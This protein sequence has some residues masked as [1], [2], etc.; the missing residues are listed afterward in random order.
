MMERHANGKGSQKVMI[1]M[2]FCLRLSMSLGTSVIPLMIDAVENTFPM[3]VNAAPIG[4]AVFGM[5]KIL[6]PFLINYVYS[7]CANRKRIIFSV[8]LL[9]LM[10]YVLGLMS[11]SE[12]IVPLLRLSLFLG[13]GFTIGIS[14]G[15]LECVDLPFLKEQSS[16]NIPPRGIHMVMLSIAGPCGSLVSFIVCSVTIVTDCYKWE[17]AYYVFSVISGTVSVFSACAMFPSLTFVFTAAITRISSNA[18]KIVDCS[19]AQTFSLRGKVTTLEDIIPPQVDDD[20]DDDDEQNV[21]TT[22]LEDLSPARDQTRHKNYVSSPIMCDKRSKSLVWELCGCE[23]Y[24]SFSLSCVY[25]V[26]F[27]AT[28]MFWGPQLI[29]ETISVSEYPQFHLLRLCIS[30]FVA[31]VLY[32]LA[33]M[34]IGSQYPLLDKGHGKHNANAFFTWYFGDLNVMI[35][36]KDNFKTYTTKKRIENYMTNKTIGLAG[37]VMSVAFMGVFAFDSYAYVLSFCMPLLLISAMHITI[38]YGK[39]ITEMFPLYI[40]DI[41]GSTAIDK[42]TSFICLLTPLCGT[43]PMVFTVQILRKEF[44][45]RDAML[46]IAVPLTLFL[47]WQYR[48]SVNL[49]NKGGKGRKKRATFVYIVSLCILPCILA[50]LLMPYEFMSLDDASHTSA[51]EAI[52]TTASE[53]PVVKWTETYNPSTI[54]DNNLFLLKGPRI[55]LS[56]Y[57]MDVDKIMTGDMSTLLVSQTSKV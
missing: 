40:A 52:V 32:K 15:I 11:N 46:A 10:G 4:F 19:N 6:C 2:V 48:C 31:A 16:E 50:S 17:T 49:Y 7:L 53:S 36:S 56:N 51:P 47:L 29:S 20:D 3:L 45:P 5:S 38:S 13:S 33:S 42:G 1:F 41:H 43:I 54:V 55:R 27:C 25:W 34:F 28:V 14:S 24:A 39:L 21:I 44:G 18:L 37:V 30:A 12:N 57:A 22:T 9:S 35:D 8:S 26:T 23:E